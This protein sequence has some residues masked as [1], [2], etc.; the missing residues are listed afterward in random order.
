MSCRHP[1][2]DWHPGRGD[3]PNHL[4]VG[5][6]PFPLKVQPFSG[7]PAI[8]CWMLAEHAFTSRE[9]SRWDDHAWHGKTCIPWVVPPPS[10][11]GNEGL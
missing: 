7:E 5:N 8:S 4:Q 6:L 1:G 2:S 9:K 3:N 11:S 10:N